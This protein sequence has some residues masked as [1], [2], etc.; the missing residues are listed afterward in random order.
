V[1]SFQKNL[2][3]HMERCWRTYWNP[4]QMW[5]TLAHTR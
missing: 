4:I 1:T 3:Q 5:T 2:T